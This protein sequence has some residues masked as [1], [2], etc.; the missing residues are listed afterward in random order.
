MKKQIH[1]SASS[2]AVLDPASRQRKAEKIVRVLASKADLRSAKL[3]DIGTG[4]GYIAHHLSPH[5]A[6]VTSIDVVD[7]RQVTDGYKFVVVQTE[8]MPFEDDCFDV[9]VSNHVI[10]HVPDQALHVSEIMRVLKPGG[11]AYFA[12]PNRLWLIDP[13]Y[14]L[15]FIN[16][17]PRSAAKTYLRIAQSKLWDI[18]PVTTGLIRRHVGPVVTT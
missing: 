5:V 18:Y 14:R 9:V 17:L 8:A 16:W 2:H 1:K 13:H 7:E 3:L 11:I 6:S 12:T 10:E 15:P 4:A